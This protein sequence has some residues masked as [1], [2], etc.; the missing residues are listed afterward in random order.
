MSRYQINKAEITLYQNEQHRGARSIV[1]KGKHQ[2]W[3][4]AVKMFEYEQDSDRERLPSS[5]VHEL[6]LLHR[7]KHENIV[8]LEGFVVNHKEK[9]AWTVFVWEENGNL[10]E[11]VSSKDWQLSQRVS[12]LY[13]IANGLEYLHGQKP[14]ICHGNLTSL[15][16]LVNEGNYAVITGFCSARVLDSPEVDPDHLV[17][18]APLQVSAEDALRVD[19]QDDTGTITLT[20]PLCSMR[21]VAPELLPGSRSSL[22]GDMWA[23]GWALSGSIPLGDTKSANT[24]MTYTIKGD[25]F[26]NEGIEPMELPRADTAI[27]GRERR[28][29]PLFEAIKEVLTRLQKASSDKWDL[30]PTAV[31]E[32][33]RELL[34]DKCFA[35]AERNLIFAITS[36]AHCGIPIGCADA[37]HDLGEVYGAQEMLDHAELCFVTAKRIGT[38]LRNNERTVQATLRL[39]LVSSRQGKL[40]KAEELLAEYTKTRNDYGRISALYELGSLYLQQDVRV[41]AEKR[42]SEALQICASIGDDQCADVL[43]KLGNHYLEQR[44]YAKA[45]E[46]STR[47]LSVWISLSRDYERALTHRQLG[48]LNRD[49]SRYTEAEDHYKQAFT[50][51]NKAERLARAIMLDRLGGLYLKQGRY[52]EAEKHCTEALTLWEHSDQ[53]RTGT[54]QKLGELCRTQARYSEARLHFTRAIDKL[55]WEEARP[56]RAGMLRELADLYQMQSRYSDAVDHLTKALSIYAS[57]RDESNRAKTLHYLGN[58]RWRQGRHLRAEEYFI[59]ARAAYASLGDNLSHAEVLCQ[60]ANLCQVQDCHPEAEKHF[61][62]AMTLLTLAGAKSDNVEVLLK[63]GQLLQQRNQYSKAEE[64][65]AEALQVSTRAGDDL[66][67]ANSL[68][69][70]GELYQRQARYPS[71]EESFT[72]ALQIYTSLGDH[73]GQKRTQSSLADILRLQCRFADAEA[74]FRAVAAFYSQIGH[75]LGD[76]YT[77]CRLGDTYRQQGKYSEASELYRGA[78][79]VFENLNHTPGFADAL[80][81]LGHV[82]HLQGQYTRARSCFF[83]AGSLY[84]SIGNKIGAAEATY[85]KGDV[86]RFQG[87]Y[88]QASEFYIEARSAYQRVG[89]QDQP[90]GLAGVICGLGYVHCFQGR[91]SEAHSCFKEAKSLY[92]KVGNKLGVAETFC[93]LGDLHRSQ[94]DYLKAEESYT[95]AQTI[96]RQLN[97]FLGVG[98]VACGLGYLRRMQCRDADAESLFNEAQKLCSEGEHG[99]GAANAALGLATVHLARL[100]CETAASHVRKALDFYTQADVLPSKARALLILAQ[101]RGLEHH[102]NELSAYLD[103]ASAIFSEIGDE[104][105]VSLCREHRLHLA[106]PDVEAPT[107]TST[108]ETTRADGYGTHINP[109]LDSVSK[110]T[111]R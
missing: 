66:S 47:A 72:T 3:D 24:I 32:R 23:F 89:H 57:L 79:D 62:E 51:Y 5:L 55:I 13:D 80:I 34:R 54:L 85:G 9:I 18:Q 94:G 11:F 77:K 49:R 90:L 97:H 37:I 31:L 22:A 7:L 19:F 38:L 29:P 84:A 50:V 27:L 103:E 87:K 53:Y 52:T 26:A 69:K 91:H 64:L 10:K 17:E 98:E 28:G 63:F 4:V 30:E 36:Y 58:L 42:F 1:T 33:G 70:L 81:G 45:E 101:I 92:D 104:R 106:L 46:L 20:G 96:Y 40:S 41:E 12:L 110:G 21:L 61:A 88:D 59:E 8:K 35:E 75:P 108:E 2:Y 68:R 102:D 111:Y 15:N 86:Y 67:R 73:L 99:L 107:L 39:G 16:I 74:A 100:E 43:Q 60:L 44:Q 48:D 56:A 83:E 6:S 109:P 71:A 82:L 95:E 78:Q 25:M 105:G 76:A 65:F 14:P 93:G